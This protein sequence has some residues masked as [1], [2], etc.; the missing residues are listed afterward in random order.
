MEVSNSQRLNSTT[1]LCG[2]SSVFVT[3]TAKRK[4][5]P[6][7]A[8]RGAFGS[9]MSGFVVTISSLRKMSPRSALS[10]ATIRNFQPV[11]APGTVNVNETFPSA[12]V[13][14]FGKKNAVSFRFVRGGASGPSSFADPRAA[15]AKDL[16][17]A[18]HISFIAPAGAATA[19]QT[20]PPRLRRPPYSYI[21]RHDGHWKLEDHVDLLG[22]RPPRSIRSVVVVWMAGFP[23][24]RVQGVK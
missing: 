17:S 18:K 2:A 4:S 22:N 5:S 13:S 10:C 12:S 14:R 24:Q 23:S 1:P 20:I 8:K 11:S 21:G 3:F 16:S 15:A 7:R 9:H 6:S 19:L